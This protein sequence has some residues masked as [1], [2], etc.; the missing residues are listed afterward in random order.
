MNLFKFFVNQTNHSPHEILLEPSAMQLAK[1]VRNEI[2]ICLSNK[3]GSVDAVRVKSISGIRYK[4]LWSNMLLQTEVDSCRMYDT[5]YRMA[6]MVDEN[7]ETI[8]FGT[9]NREK[10]VHYF[11]Y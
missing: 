2:Q 6:K 5:S 11:H 9:C 8:Y 1:H 7:V 4:V 10:S 3:H